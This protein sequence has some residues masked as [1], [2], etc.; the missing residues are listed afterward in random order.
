MLC[1][2]Y[3]WKIPKTLVFSNKCFVGTSDPGLFY[4]VLQYVVVHLCENVSYVKCFSINNFL[5][6][7]LVKQPVNDTSI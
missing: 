1:S 3:S 2:Q 6:R 4:E 7:I 5:D